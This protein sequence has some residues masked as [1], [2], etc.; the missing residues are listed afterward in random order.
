MSQMFKK[1]ILYFTQNIGEKRQQVVYHRCWEAILCK[2]PLAFTKCRYIH[3]ATPPC[4]QE[5]L[6]EKVTKVKIDDDVSTILWVF[7]NQPSIKQERNTVLSSLIQAIK[8][9]ICK[10]NRKSVTEWMLKSTKILN[11]QWMA[12]LSWKKFMTEESSSK[13]MASWSVFLPWTIAIKTEG[14]KTGG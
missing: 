11:S 1:M 6:C 4:M 8:D 5:I 2:Q 10:M 14:F 13:S 7:P 3:Y 12:K 9:K